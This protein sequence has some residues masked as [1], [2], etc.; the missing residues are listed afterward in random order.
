ML[1]HPDGP[2]RRDYERVTH[3]VRNPF[4]SVLTALERLGRRG[5]SAVYQSDADVA[6][7]RMAAAEAGVHLGLRDL[8]YPTK[9][10]VRCELRPSQSTSESR[11]WQKFAREN[12]F[13]PTN[14]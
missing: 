6:L 3:R 14:D 1:T 8:V 7:L 10:C 13:E 2:F 11:C 4:A 9:P 12:L 5:R